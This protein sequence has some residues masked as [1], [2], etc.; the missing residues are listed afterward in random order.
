M[1]L[2]KSTRFVLMIVLAFLLFN[3]ANASSSIPK[4]SFVCD[5]CISNSDFKRVANRHL[6]PSTKKHV[7]VFNRPKSLVKKFHVEN[8]SLSTPGFRDEPGVPTSVNHVYELAVESYISALFEEIVA[9][10]ARLNDRNPTYSIPSDIALS[11]YDLVG[12]TAVQNN[13]E[14]YLF[15]EFSTFGNAFIM[16]ERTKQLAMEFVNLEFEGSFVNA[17]FA[18]GTTVT[19][20]MVFSGKNRDGKYTL[21]FRSGKDKYNNPI[22]MD[23]KDYLNNDNTYLFYQDM[24]SAR[25]FMETMIRM[26]QEVA[27]NN[28][29]RR[30]SMQECVI[31]GGGITCWAPDFRTSQ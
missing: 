5:S 19:F 15:S 18:D 24:A 17:Y 4:Y 16:L 20:E 28:I 27:I 7:Y 21:E 9:Y 31:T 3:D 25:A 12:T 11:A 13:V 26:E 23:V 10:Q 1:F 8:M 6:E 14:D 30:T 22:Y 2:F 29:L